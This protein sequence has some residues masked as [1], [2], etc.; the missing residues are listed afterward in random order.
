MARLLQ[1]SFGRLVS[2]YSCVRNLL[3]WATQATNTRGYFSLASFILTIVVIEFTSFTDYC[4]V[5]TSILSR[6]G[7]KC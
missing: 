1:V 5:S 7:F 2:Y 3:H 4:S 6:I